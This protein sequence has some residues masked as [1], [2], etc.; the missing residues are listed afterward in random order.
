MSDKLGACRESLLCFIR[1]H[2]AQDPDQVNSCDQPLIS[3]GIIDSFAL[4][5]LAVFI[6]EEF[7]VSVPDPEMTVANFDTVDLGAATIMRVSG[8]Q[9]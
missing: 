7:G 6:E 2:L 9:A 4:V 5:E 8:Q 3:S 1:D